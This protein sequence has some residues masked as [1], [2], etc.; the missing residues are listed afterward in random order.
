MGGMKEG[1]EEGGSASIG[2]K[3]PVTRKKLFIEIIVR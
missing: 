3:L 2:T 1:R